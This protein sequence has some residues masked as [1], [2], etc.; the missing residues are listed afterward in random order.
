LNFANLRVC[1]R[2][3]DWRGKSANE[4]FANRRVDHSSWHFFQAR[5]WLDYATREDAPSAI[6]Y[7]AFELRYGIEYLLFE[8]LVVTSESLSLEEYKQIIGNPQAMKKLLRSQPRN[9]SK[10]SEFAEVIVSV[11]PQAPPIHFWDLND[12]F[13]YWG[14]ASEYLHFVGAHSASYYRTDW[15]AKAIARLDSVLHPIWSAVTTTVGYGVMRPS[16]MP[17]EVHQAWTQFK[18]GT[19]AKDDLA[20][21]LMIMQPALRMRRKGETGWQHQGRR[22]FQIPTD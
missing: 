9:Y 12:L 19:L 7:A 17:P 18:D 20:C 4:I 5:S 2:V 1:Y 6:H 8:L 21:R 14:V 22:F 11:D 16:Q 13:R 10:L 15:T 3:H